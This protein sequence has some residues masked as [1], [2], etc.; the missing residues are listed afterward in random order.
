MK[1][2]E[3]LVKQEDNGIRVW[4]FVLIQWK[5]IVKSREQMRRCF[6][7]REVS[8]NGAVA[9][10]TK[11]LAAND[12]VQ[13]KFD[14]VAA[15]ESRYGREKLDL[16]YEDNYLAVVVKP[17]GMTM[18]TLGFMLPYSLCLEEDNM[19][20]RQ[21]LSTG[22][23]EQ[24]PLIMEDG[25]GESDTQDDEDG[26]FD[27]LS[28][29]SPALGQQSRFPCAVHGLEKA[30]NGLVLV[31]KTAETHAL[32]L[33]MHRDREIRRTFR[34]ICHGDWTNG[35]VATPMDSEYGGQNPILKDSAALD[36]ECIETI[37]VVMVTSSNEA[38]SLS[39]LDVVPHSPSMGVNIRRYLMSMKHPVV[40]DSGNT[41]PLKANR[42]KGLQSALVK[43]EFIHPRSGLPVSLSLEEPAKFE[44][45]RNREQKACLQRQAN[46]L[47]ELKKGGLDPVSSTYDRQT[48]LPIAYMV[49]EKDFC[50]M[51][52]KVSSATLI[53]RSST[54]TLVQGAIAFAQHHSIKI[55]D[56]GTGSGCLL[57]AL[58]KSLPS[59]VGFGVDISQEALEIARTNSALHGLDSQAT[60]RI[61][62]LGE[63][64][65]SL[66][67]LQ[68]FDLLVCNPPYLD[69]SKST[70]LTKLY[71]GTEF[72]P[73]V[74][75]FADS[76]GYGA[77]EL[78]ATCLLRDLKAPGSNHVMARDGYIILEI[79][80]GM[81]QRVR[82]IFWFLHFESAVK[83]RQ[84]SE[85]CLVFSI[86]SSNLPM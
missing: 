16:R 86:Q 38:G 49:G 83:D 61:G 24:E 40:G 62:D 42:N 76:E 77:Y 54:E 15:H 85:R 82:D 32:L 51:R 79:G 27:V 1:A 59:A 5:S 25:C 45:I 44:Q 10:I 19:S 80:T 18:V 65:G 22:T 29:V 50:G 60:F 68:S 69:A 9:E 57:L 36:T 2:L 78:L 3:S 21:N 37:N 66:D 26:G 31:A 53:P 55:L 58:L 74:A 33:Q 34:V 8:V 84:G 4:K 73:P 46:D 56:V 28:N 14:S 75:L 17:S 35:K 63:L 67:L 6:K 7:R 30:S 41:K 23:L 52:F 13:I 20:P 70:K 64:D 72:E 48:E 12:L 11:I 71:A 81:G 43:V 39:T 47:D